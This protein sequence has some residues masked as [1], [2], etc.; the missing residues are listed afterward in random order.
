MASTAHNI[1]GLPGAIT[2]T[3]GLPSVLR[4]LTLAEA[5][6]DARHLS[7]LI[8]AATDSVIA[9]S[10]ECPRD[11]VERQAFERATAFLWVAR[12]LAELLDWKLDRMDTDFS[13]QR[14]HQP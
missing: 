12:D 5:A 11:P 6:S 1:P 3:T 14:K 7:H 9:M 2:A 4:D 10:A 13:L 8:A